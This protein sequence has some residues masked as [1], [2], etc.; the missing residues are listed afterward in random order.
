[1]CV[2]LIVLDRRTSALHDGYT[3]VY[4]DERYSAPVSADGIDV[5]GQ[6]VSCGYAVIEMFS[7]YAG[8]R[9]T[10]QQLYGE[11]GRV[12]TSTGENFCAEMNK[13][14]PRFD[15]SMWKYLPDSELVAAVYV[16]LS[17]GVPV[18]FEWAAKRDGEWTLHYSLVT[19]MDIPAD[20]VTAANPY[21]YTEQITLGEFLDR[22]SFEA[23]ADMPLFLKMGFAFGIFEKNTVYIPKVV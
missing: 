21:G 5:F 14:F 20:R 9:V 4:D 10:E 18:P 23:Y 13:R 1:M 8:E 3:R 6:Q 12:V 16:S 19:G 15:T 7:Q 22:T 2:S 17:E 11:Y